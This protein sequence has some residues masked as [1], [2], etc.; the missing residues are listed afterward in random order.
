MDLS[1]NWLLQYVDTADID[2]K[3]FCDRMTDSG[4][5]VEGCTVLGAD[6]ENVVVG[7]V[8]EIVR[9]PDSDHMWICQVRV[10]PDRVEQIVTGAQNVK[11]GDLVPAALSPSRLPGGKTIKAG[12]LRGVDSNGMLCSMSELGLD[13]HD[14]PGKIADGILI[15]D[16]TDEDVGKSVNEVLDLDDSVVEFEITSNRPDCLSVIGLAR[17]AAVTFGR[18]FSVSEP[19]VRRENKKDDISNYLSVSIDC[20]DLCRRYAARVVTDVK[21][22]PSP[23]WLRRR[24]R[25]SGVRPIN[26]IVDITNYVMLEYGQP[27]H[28]FDYRMLE[29]SRIEVRRAK[30]GEN[31]RTLDGQDHVLDSSMMVIADAAKACALAGV[32]GGENSEIRP[33]TVTVVFESANFLGTSVRR[34]AQKNGTRTESSSRFE[35]GL[36]PENCLPA[37]ERACELVEELGAGTVAGGIIDVYPGREPAYT[38]PFEP[39]RYNAFLGTDIPES[40]MI[41]TLEKLGCRV[42]DGI[43]TVPSFR[44]DLRCMNDIAEEVVR[45]HGYN[46]IPSTNIRAEATQGGRTP[47]QRYLYDLEN[48]LTGIGLSSIQ[49]FTFVSPKIYDRIRLPESDPLRR[50]VVTSN[51]LGEDTSVMRTVALPSMLDVLSRNDHFSNPK[52]DLFEI[53]TVYLPHESNEELPDEKLRLTLGLYGPKTDFYTLKGI[54]ETVMRVS[55]LKDVTYRAYTESPAFHPGRCA[56]VVC[57]DGTSL[58]LFGQIHPLTADNFDLDIPV[59]AADLDLSALCEKADPSCHYTPLPKY[60]A[61]SRD[62]AFLC[63]E[64]LEV[65]TLEAVV[66]R[67]GGALTE[68]VTLFDIYRG[69]QVGEGK[70]SVALHVVLRAKDHTLTFEEAE[71]AAAKI[72]KDVSYKLGLTLRT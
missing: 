72:R 36:D 39:D 22:Q 44:A 46:S 3:T 10:G 9:H 5:K 15:L 61:V 49:T 37:L 68:S 63:D 11:A 38:M 27:M 21:I 34:T 53:A 45:I 62:F 51:P 54:V 4:S 64:D 35:K 71:K 18:P 23:Q 20:P 30:D 56:E 7:R 1:R 41:S 29:G 17:E 48:T 24:L 25:A 31:F 59:F 57:A 12:K 66:S 55:G 50:S 13:E 14:C 60:P 69:P 67:A 19:L 70:K 52:A 26:N 8:E 43:I 58:G 28:A 42:K 65:G 47:R 6:I 33:D 2:N 32:M 40:F 16:G